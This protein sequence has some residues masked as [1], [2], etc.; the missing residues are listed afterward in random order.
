VASVTRYSLLNRSAAVHQF[1]S[2]TLLVSVAPQHNLQPSIDRAK[3]LDNGAL[4]AIRLQLTHARG[5]Q[6]SKRWILQNFT[7]TL[8]DFTLH[9]ILL[10]QINS[11]ATVP[12]VS[13]QPWAG[14]L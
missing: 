3:Q 6:K 13:C 5:N 2:E 10:K 12:F 1:T 11:R 14:Q 4:D 8:Q 7:S 9:L